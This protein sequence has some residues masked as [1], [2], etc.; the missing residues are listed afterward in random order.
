[1]RR[2]F[3]LYIRSLCPLF[4][5]NDAAPT[6]IYTLSLH[7][8]LP[9]SKKWSKNAIPDGK[10]T[11]RAKQSL[12]PTSIGVMCYSLAATTLSIIPTSYSGSYPICCAIALLKKFGLS[13]FQ[14]N[15][16]KTAS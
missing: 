1:C 13:P 7:D 5:F 10:F 14:E 16:D 6:Q 15:K 3:R 9:I 4:F 12:S 8:A 11:T 2:L